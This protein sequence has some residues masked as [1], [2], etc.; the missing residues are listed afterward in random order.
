M[1]SEHYVLYTKTPE[2]PEQVFMGGCSHVSEFSSVECARNSNCHGIYQDKIKYKIAKIK[3][4]VIRTIL[5]DDIDPPTESEMEKYTSELKYSIELEEEM[6]LLGIT[7]PYEKFQYEIDKRFIKRVV[8]L[9][10]KQEFNENSKSKNKKRN[11]T[12][13]RK[14]VRKN[15]K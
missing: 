1:I 6:K 15:K 2:E 8:E 12:R 5:E 3:K 13:K 4:E 11:A 9:F 10:E 14:V 7:D